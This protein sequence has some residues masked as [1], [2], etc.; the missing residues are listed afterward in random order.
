[1]PNLKSIQTEIDAAYLYGRLAEIEEDKEVAGI[2][3][4]MSEIEM[5]H[6]SSFLE[7]SGLPPD[8]MPG[9]SFRAKT[10]NKIGKVFGMKNQV[11]FV[12]GDKSIEPK[13]RKLTKKYGP[14]KVVDYKPYL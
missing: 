2:F 9:P 12:L 11:I 6:A 13:L 3:K 10:L 1:M 5:G 8:Q 4:Q 14:L 7:K